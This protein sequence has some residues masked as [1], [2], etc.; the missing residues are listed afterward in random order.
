MDRVSATSEATLR[1]D[2]AKT[3]RL[4]GTLELV[5][6]VFNHISARLND[7]NN[8]V[9]FLMNRS[10]RVA[11]DA[12]P[13][14]LVIVDCSS[15]IEGPAIQAGVLLHRAIYRNRRDVQA[16]IHLHSTAAT[17]VSTLKCGLLKLT[18]TAMEFAD[19]IAYCEFAGVVESNE[20]GAR[21]AACLSNLPCA[22]LRNHG[23][24]TVGTSIQEAFYIAYYLEEACRLQ[25]EVL[26]CQIPYIAPDPAICTL[27]REQLKRQRSS[28]SISMWQAMTKHL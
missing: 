10:D 14:D 6:T 23:L 12:Q 9:R 1:Q 2:L 20:E 17:A 19:E 15:S 28:A 18:Q 8:N 25:L 21:V 22:L 7:G 5:D 24:L 13:E 26:A 16:I 11:V 4:C 3:W 27:T